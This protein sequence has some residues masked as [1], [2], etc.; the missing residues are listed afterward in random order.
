MPCNKEQDQSYSYEVLNSL[1]NRSALV[2]SLW[3]LEAV[4]A[5]LGSE[6]RGENTEG[7]IESYLITLD[8]LPIF[9]DSLTVHNSFGRTLSL[10]RAFNLSSYDA[11][12]LELAIRESLPLATLDKN[13]AKAAI[14]SDVAIYLKAG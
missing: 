13:L 9:V 10:A 4:S 1:L 11:C 6:R 12:Y 5:L 3:H 7:Q 2:P 14:R 8:K